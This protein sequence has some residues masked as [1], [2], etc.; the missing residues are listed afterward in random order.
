MF[1]NFSMSKKH[2]T[3]KIWRTKTKFSLLLIT[4][5]IMI[6]FSSKIYFKILNYNCYHKCSD[7]HLSGDASH[8]NYNDFMIDNKDTIW[9]D[10]E[11][12]NDWCICIDE[13]NPG[14]C[15]ALLRY[16]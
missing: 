16:L 10:E 9:V 15:C 14:L 11:C 3:D 6:H 12:Y 7:Y 13:C 5:I 8:W 2:S 1:V 4:G